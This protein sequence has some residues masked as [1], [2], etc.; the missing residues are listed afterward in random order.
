M[1]KNSII[2]CS[3]VRVSRIAFAAAGFV[4]CAAPAR[5]AE[6]RPL[7]P[8][9][10][11][12][13]VEVLLDGTP[14][15]SFW[16]EGD[17]FVLGHL[18]DRSTIRVSNHTSRRVEAV[19]SVDGRD[20]IDGK[21]GDFARKSGYLVPAWGQVEIDGWRLSQQQ[22]A[23]FRFSSVADSYASRMGSARN[24]GVIGVAIFPERLYRPPP[25]PIY[26]AIPYRDG[27]QHRLEGYGS[28]GFDKDQ[29]GAAPAARASASA[30]ARLADKAPAESEAKGA[31]GESYAPRKSRPGLGTEFGEAVSSQIREVEFT[32]ANP[33]EPAAVIGLRYNDRAGLIAM[34][35]DVDGTWCCSDD[36]HLRRNADPFPVSHTRYARP[37]SGWQQY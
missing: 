6:S 5:N 36:S 27:Y 13:Q 30:Q 31:A 23:A 22:A 29:L 14:A 20:V 3:P 35:I 15:Q 11:G 10:G 7:R 12:Y 18:G 26:P 33:S 4:A 9:A 16:H 28:N 1:K 8:E 32:R 34:G 37:P 2:C 24:V 19:V 21:P 17:T 25:R